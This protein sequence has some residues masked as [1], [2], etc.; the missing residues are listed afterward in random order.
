[1]RCCLR[2]HE[3]GWREIEDEIVVLD[4]RGAVYLAA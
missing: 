4:E 1:M 3:L 2:E